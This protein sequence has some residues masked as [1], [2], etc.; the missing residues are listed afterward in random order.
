MIKK[1]IEKE[2]ENA[3]RKFPLFASWHEAYAVIKD[4]VEEAQEEVAVMAELDT[5][6]FWSCIRSKDATDMDRTNSLSRI[7]HQAVRGIEELVQVAA[8]CDKTLQSLR[9]EF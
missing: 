9:K 8:M 6:E 1:L 3:N 2:L 5:E 7:R 4:E